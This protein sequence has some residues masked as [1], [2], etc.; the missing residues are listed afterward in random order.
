MS[1]SPQF[2][3][4]VRFGACELDPAARELRVAGAPVRVGERG[5]DLLLALAEARGEV[6]SRDALLDRVWRE[7]VVG[8]E[9]LKVQ[10]MALRKL[11]GADAIVTVPGRGYR[12]ALPVEARSAAA[13]A[14]GAVALFGRDEDLQRVQ[15]AL[16]ER[17]LVTLAGPG[18]IGKT[19]LALA[20]A[21]ASRFGDGH[22]VVELAA[23][24]DAGHLVHALSRSLG[25]P[26]G[27]GKAALH[28]ALRPL[29]LLLVLDNAEHLLEGVAAQA[30][31][32]LAAAPRLR[33]LVTSREPLHVD[34]EQVLRLDGL[35]L[36]ANDDPA[37]VRASPAVALLCTRVQAR[38]PHFA[39]TD[40]QAPV[41]AALCRRLEGIPLA[42]E[43]A[44]ARVPLLGL[45]GVLDRL[46]E[47][48]S[49]LTRGTHGAPERQQTLR[50]ALAWSHGLLDDAE[51]RVFRRLAVFAGGFRFASAQRLLVDSDD[52]SAPDEWQAIDLVQGLADKSLL[53]LQADGDGRRLRMAEVTR[54]FALER[55]LVSGEQ[56]AMQRRHA[57][58][59]LALFEEADERYTA[60]PVLAWT[61]ELMPELANLRASLHWALGDDGRAGDETLAIRLMGASGG[62]WALAGLLGESAPL[63]RRLA[64]RV[65]DPLP[66]RAQAL[67]WMAV[68]NRGSDPAFST[69]EAYEALE[70]VIAL[71]RSGGLQALLHRALS[72]RPQ[73]GV[74]LGLAVDTDATVAEMRACEGADWSSLQRRGRRNCENFALFQRGD[75]DAYAQTQRQ[76]LRLNLEAGEDYHAWLTAHR[77]ALAEIARGRAAEAVALM[78]PMVERIRAQGFQRHCWQQVAVLTVAQI[79]HGDAPADAV[80]ETVRLL[81]GAGA[82][83]WMASHFAEWLTQ[84]GCWADAARLLGWVEARTAASGRAPDPQTRGAQ[85]RAQR[86]LDAQASPAQA[87]AWRD[88]GARWI[89]DD[90]A[91]ALLGVT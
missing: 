24:V 13:P 41:A 69:E 81:R 56:A 66:L 70:R 63:L 82:M 60:T 8:D 91:N 37:A 15:A 14:A 55:L 2:I 26:P 36:P 83:D 49:L 54:A 27:S 48:L 35:A 10:V 22:V 33:L 39:L 71:A 25:L 74:R 30:T 68:A 16:A 90:V 87:T 85:E 88:E 19:R 11:I 31:E 58:A 18:G 79:E 28:S 9:N 57:E 7:V 45:A 61:R 80:H 40:E 51:K 50:G 32:L 52:P 76:E 59:V 4:P 84:R 6:V 86:A 29:Q 20:S 23:L 75:W 64:P 47:P 65:H 43:L 46:A 62:F 73:L 5:F 38:D 17:R 1:P 21:A 3:S 78:R 44:A 77:L 42:I 67:F 53:A 72:L 89:D 34:E 12:L